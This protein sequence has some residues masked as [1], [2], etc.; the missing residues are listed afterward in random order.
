MKRVILIWMGALF[1][2]SGAA[3]AQEPPRGQLLDHGLWWLYQLQYDKARADFDLYISSHPQDPEGYFYRTATDWWH[4]AQ[5]F[6]YKLPEIQKQFEE[7]SEKTI[8]VARALHDSTDN[9]KIQSRALLYWG[10]AEGLR[11]RW[12]VTQHQWVP[13]YFAGKRGARYLRRAVHDDPTQYD[14][15]MGLG[16]YDY[17]T[18]TLSGVQAAL[19]ALL[20]HGDKARGLR[21]LQIAIDKSKHA[22]V[23]AM[24]FLIEI[25]DAEENTPAKALPLARALHKEFPQSPAMHLILMS[26]LYIMKDWEGMLPEANE[27]LEKSEKEVPWYTQTTILPAQYCIGVGLLF[28]KHDLNGAFDQMEKILS[29]KIDE[30][31][32]VTFALLR[33]GQ[34]YDLRGE[35]DKAMINYRQVLSRLD[36]WGTHTEA[37]QYL[38]E[39]FK[40]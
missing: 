29:G 27:I 25:Y 30:N 24:T 21:E 28:G 26:T 6:E 36:T 20:I 12:L 38:K 22:R 33:Q 8:A 16:I 34:I 32:W 40:F 19:A 15:Y 31:R 18:D 17:F 11:G 14:A 5:E 7:D 2:W 13:A 37:A 39:P 3:I 4:L 23:E 35:R 1:L 10:G 9:R